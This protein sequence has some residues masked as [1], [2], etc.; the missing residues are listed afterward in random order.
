V[1][2]A[3]NLC[4]AFLLDTFVTEWK[5]ARK[6]HRRVR[7]ESVARKAGRRTNRPSLLQA[8]SAQAAN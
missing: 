2:L 4:I 3:L 5:E 6:Q 8:V 7:G 1:V